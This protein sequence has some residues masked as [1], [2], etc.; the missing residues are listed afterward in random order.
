MGVYT[1]RGLLVSY[2][3]SNRRH[4]HTEPYNALFVCKKCKLEDFTG[5]IDGLCTDCFLLATDKKRG[6]G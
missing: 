1:D 3:R 6:E 4:K 5:L 2:R